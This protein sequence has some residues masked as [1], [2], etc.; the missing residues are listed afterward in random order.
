MGIEFD[1]STTL[2]VTNGSAGM[3]KSGIPPAQEMLPIIQDALPG[4]E[5]VSFHSLLRAPQLLKNRNAIVLGGDGSAATTATLQAQEHPDG[6]T[7]PL[8]CAT[9]GVITD[10]LGLGRQRDE[11]PE[12]YAHRM[13]EAIK[14]RSFTEYTVPAGSIKLARSDILQPFS[15]ASGVGT[16]TEIYTNATNRLRS[17]KLQA[18]LRSMIAVMETSLAFRRAPQFTIVY[19]KTAHPIIEMQLLKYPFT[20]PKL[21]TADTPSDMLLSLKAPLS[22]RIASQLCSDAFRLF[23]LHQQAHHDVLTLTPIPE[24]ISIYLHTPA[25]SRVALTVESEN[26]PGL[27]A[28]RIIGTDRN[29]GIIYRYASLSQE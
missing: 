10:R 18:S 7:L 17:R 23:V 16:I 3:S 11:T 13:A 29:S 12:S 21:Q 5:V 15:F 20:Y 8:D 25:K 22:L 24:G 14:R 9:I 6:F 2:I 27:S 1:P 28:T 4:A 26:A 19:N